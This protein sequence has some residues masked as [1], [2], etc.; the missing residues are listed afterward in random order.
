MPR[1]KPKRFVHVVYRTRRFEQMLQWYRTVFDAEVQY[2]N[3]ALA[4]LTYDGEHH[5]FA[6]ANLAV[7]DPQGSDTDR[8]GQI[9]VDHVA[10]PTTRWTSCSEAT[11]SSRR[12][13]SCPTGAC[14]TASPCGV[15]RRPGRQPDGVPGGLLRVERRGQC[16][17]A[18]AALQRQPDR[19]GIRPGGNGSPAAAAA[20]RWP[21]SSRGRATCQCRRCAAHL[22]HSRRAPV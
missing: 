14:T 16:L 22:P 11:S 13:A 5:R 18:R 19:R 1:I 8:Q 9:G 21:P 20:P 4:F 15:L 6:F 3:P 10:T 7:L 2:Q 12:W 17:Y